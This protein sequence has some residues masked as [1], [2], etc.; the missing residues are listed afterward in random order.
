MVREEGDPDAFVLPGLEGVGAGGAGRHRGRRCFHV[1]HAPVFAADH[2]LAAAHGVA[3]R[4]K[5][6]PNLFLL[7]LSAIG[8]CPHQCSAQFRL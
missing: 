6:H 7:L 3:V 8:G 2:A 5:L 4:R 1:A